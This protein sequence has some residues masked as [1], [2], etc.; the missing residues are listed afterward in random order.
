MPRERPLAERIA[1]V[2]MYHR[3]GSTRA[4]VTEWP[5][6]FPTAPPSVS[7]IHRNVHK[8]EANGSVKMQHKPHDRPIRTPENLQAVADLVATTDGPLSTR[9][10]AAQLGIS[11][12][13]YCR[14]LKD[15]GLKCYRPQLVVD[16]HGDDFNLRT[17]FSN[18]WY[19]NFVD[20]QQLV[21]RIFWSDEAKFC[22]NGHVNK[23]NCCYWAY[24]NPQIQIPVAND[25][26]GVN[27][28]CGLSSAGILGPYFFDGNV[29][30]VAYRELL[31]NIAGP[32]VLQNQLILQQDG[33]P[34]HFGLIVRHWLNTN[35]PH[36]WIG[37]GGEFDLN[38]PWPPRSPDLTVCDFFLWGYVK[39]KVFSHGIPASLDELRDCIQEECD[40]VPADM[41]ARACRSVPSRYEDCIALEGKALPY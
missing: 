21:D 34:P 14:A 36:R 8:F 13:S 33:A 18:H 32:H 25:Q 28:W 30:A 9:R 39:E 31:V 17:Q 6:A 3:L 29:T 12:T 41:C 19:Y 20:D 22:M 15:V 4:V 38:F 27:V 5:N 7:T 11:Q 2:N 24:E 1:M 35:L 40:A 16:L 26:R 37:R 10:G 23:H